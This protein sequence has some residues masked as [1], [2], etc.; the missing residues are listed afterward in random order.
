MTAG[1]MAAIE[2]SCLGPLRT[3][4]GPA[5]ARMRLHQAWFRYIRL[6]L[7]RYGHLPP[8][9]G[10]PLGSVLA[11]QDAMRGANFTSAQAESLYRRRRSSGWGVDPFRCT[12]IMTSSQ[13]FAINVMG[14]L[15]KNLAW[16]RDAF[17]LALELSIRRVL[18]VDI[19]VAPRLKKEHLND[20]T[21]IDVVVD[22]ESES[23]ERGSIAFEVKL[24]DRYV[25][26]VLAFGEAY[27]RLVESS[28]IWIAAAET[29]VESSI[30][31][32]FRVHALALSRQTSLGFSRQP[33]MVLLHHPLDSRAI[34]VA[35]SYRSILSDA[36]WM[37]TLNAATLIQ[38]MH[39]AAPD[40]E[41]RKIAEL[42]RTRYLDLDLTDELHSNWIAQRRSV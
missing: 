36:K 10:R 26:R 20:R 23:G 19:E 3:Q 1:M 38:A 39:V 42:L 41:S 32:L 34:G 14:P 17:S 33:V 6:G 18:Q 8:P 24:L 35:S 16:A 9:S 29:K 21:L 7:P 2:L 30:N 15:A 28:G 40:G 22:F 11:P 5:E 12:S 31:Q 25:S 37:R 4:E 27:R 13:A